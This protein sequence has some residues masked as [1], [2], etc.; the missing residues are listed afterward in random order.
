MDAIISLT[1]SDDT[2]CLKSQIGHYVAFNTKD[3]PI[4]LAIYDGSGSNT[5]M[6]INHPVLAHFLC[7]VR[8]LKSF[9]ED[10]DK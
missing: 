4:C 9:S 10:A 6:C 7:L 2:S 3:Y 8:E 5:H 1:H